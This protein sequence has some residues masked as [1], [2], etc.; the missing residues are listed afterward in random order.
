MKE[1]V[2]VLFLA[3]GYSIHAVRRI[4]IFLEDPGFEVAVVSDHDYRFPGAVNV[5][6]AGKEAREVIRS[7][8]LATLEKIRR[9]TP[10][11]RLFG[12]LPRLRE[13]LWAYSLLLPHFRRLGILD[14]PTIRS[15]GN[16]LD[17]LL[18][19]ALARE[20][21]K[22]LL[23]AVE[24]F[25]PDIVF[26]QTL[27]YPC[28]LAFHLPKKYPILVTFWNGDATWWAQWDGID[29][30]V[31]RQIVSRGVERAAALTANSEHVRRSLLEIGADPGKIHLI[32]YPG[33][34]LERFA[35]GPKE[36]FRE[37]LRIPAGKVVLC[38]RGLGGYLN[39]DVIIECMPEVLRTHPDT[40]FLFLSGVGGEEWDRHVERARVLGV[41]RN[42]RR[43]GQV[44][45]ERMP[46]YYRASDA[47]VSVSSY[48]SLPN[49]MLEAMACGI[50]VVLGDLPQLREWVDNGINGL[51]VPPR[52]PVALADGI[53]E[54]FDA[55]SGRI[56]DFAL[57]NLQRV[58]R[59]VDSREAA[60]RIKRLVRDHARKR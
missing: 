19:A 25:D 33:V 14:I 4:R 29:R 2:R 58:E 37:E 1:P 15:A 30:A 6:L 59:E 3:W 34:D 8:A 24:R 49:C 53:R 23:D 31:K 17:L 27:L 21:S 40:L 48:D 9:E 42:L 11:G 18:D 28:H 46:A 50:P 12:L 20:D 22:L 55:P 36:P 26:L 47:M 16:A 44:P 38:P 35:P 7:K 51:L 43:D 54:I 60:A 5:P 32:R 39:S 57:H 41:E 45:W 10:G 13:K 52:D 56:A